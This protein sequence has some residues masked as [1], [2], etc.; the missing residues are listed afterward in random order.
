M[1]D[2]S[3]CMEDGG[4]GLDGRVYEKKLYD[5]LELVL[6]YVISSSFFWSGIFCFCFFWC[7]VSPFD[8]M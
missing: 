1:C 6:F 3:A 2:C 4:D 5:L 7:S 8:L